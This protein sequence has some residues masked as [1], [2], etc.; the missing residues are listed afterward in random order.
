MT[1][2]SCYLFTVEAVPKLQFLEQ[3]PWI[4]WKNRVFDRDFQEPTAQFFIS[5]YFKE[6]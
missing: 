4:Y 5:L 6:K 2:W 3:L 1:I